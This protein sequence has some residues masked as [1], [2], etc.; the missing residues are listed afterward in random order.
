MTRLQDAGGGEAAFTK[1]GAN[2]ARNTK[3]TAVILATFLYPTVTVRK[4]DPILTVQRTPW[5][6]NGRRAGP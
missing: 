4:V 6:K 2:K 5:P 3:A 1:N